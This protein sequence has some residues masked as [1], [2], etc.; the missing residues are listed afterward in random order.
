MIIS[1]KHK[2]I[3]VK[4]KK[5]GGTS[6]EIALSKICGP[7]DIL[8]PIRKQDEVARKA[9]A[10]ISAQNFYLPWKYYT[11]ANLLRYLAK[12]KKLPLRYY[13]HIGCQDL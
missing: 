9:Y 4:T 13:P 6:F 8:T 1:H 7:N 5:T 3:F 10:D 2:F 12:K 11:K